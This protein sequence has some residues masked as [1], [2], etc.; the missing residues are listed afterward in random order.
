MADR[1]FALSLSR[2]A[3]F[4]DDV[5]KDFDAQLTALVA[6][7]RKRPGCPKSRTLTL[8]V[9]CNPNENDQDDVDVAL[10]VSSKIPAAEHQTRR[11]RATR[12]N[13]LLL[14]F[15]EESASDGE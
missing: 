10:V 11:A 3:S 2:L 14:E 7:C 13:Q 1:T 6:D 12:N 5:A 15:E 4:S 9:E 8:K